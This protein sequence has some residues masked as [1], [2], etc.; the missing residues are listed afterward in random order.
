M[1]TK[2]KI[3]DLREEHLNLLKW[4]QQKEIGE[5]ALQEINTFLAKVRDLGNDVFNSQQRRMLRSFLTY[6]GNFVYERTGSYP[7]TTLPPYSVEVPEPEESLP[8]FVEVPQKGLLSDW[9]AWVMGGILIAGALLVFLLFRGGQWPTIAAATVTP[10]TT[11]T[12][13]PSPTPVLTPTCPTDSSKYGFESGVMG[14]MHQ[15]LEDSQA[16]T[17]VAQSERNVAKLGC[18]S[19]KLTVDLGDRQVN[20]SKG[21]AYVDIR[22]FLPAKVTAPLNLEGVQI[23]AWVYVPGA[24]GSP[25]RPNGVQLFVKDQNWRSEYG[26]WFNLTSARWILVT[27]TPLRTTPLRGGYMESGFDPTKIIMVGIKVGAGA[28][29]ETPYLGPIYVD[30]IDW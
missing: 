18:Y 26:R 17:A 19:L 7:D 27:L 20:K 24:A 30:A 12:L 2:N 8:D 4:S 10:T 25:D 6:W 16:V 29:S 23:S 21:E 28:G 5:E 9:R 14:W 22:F 3:E 15:T 11:P 1:T 13:P